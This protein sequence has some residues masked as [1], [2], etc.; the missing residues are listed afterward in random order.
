MTDN[1][2]KKLT[3]AYRWLIVPLTLIGAVLYRFRGGPEW[4]PDTPRPIKQILFS[5]FPIVVLPGEALLYKILPGGVDW[6]HEWGWVAAYVFIIL[7]AVAWECTGHG[8]Y[9]TLKYF[10]LRYV[11]PERI[12]ILLVPF[13]G[14]DPRDYKRETVINARAMP[15]SDEVVY[16]ALVRD[17]GKNK[18]YRRCVSGL[19]LT[20]IV[21]TIFAGIFVMSCGIYLAG[22]LL[23]L[24]GALKAPGYM[25]G[26]AVFDGTAAGE[27]STGGLRWGAAALIRAFLWV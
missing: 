24:T 25:F 3:K 7:W 14:K 15:A 21:T 11:K 5:L 6:R 17:Y 13:F 4:G 18:L 20:G 26:W 12:D 10:A 2:N 9:M 23:I 1:E 19:A 16:G 27:W 8:M 22:F